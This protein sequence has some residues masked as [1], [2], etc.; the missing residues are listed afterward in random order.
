MQYKNTDSNYSFITKKTHLLI[1][2][3]FV[4]QFTLVYW[5]DYVPQINPLNM[6]LVLLH[7]SFGLTLLFIGLF[8]I[9]W[10]FLNTKPKFPS[11][12]A[13][14]ETILATATHHSL[15][16]LILLMPLSGALMSLLGGHGIKWFGIPLPNYLPLNKPLSGIIY[17][18]HV[19]LS[20]LVIALVV[21][22]V[23]GALKHYFIDKNNVLQR[24]W[25]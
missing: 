18:A 22:H 20:Y 9:I 4:V 7:K 5:R 24:M 14:W 3:L 17:Q 19:Y 1:T 23:T 2:I 16:L 11:D 21:L 8:F 6:Q 15:Y 25:R 10:R 12:M 13:R